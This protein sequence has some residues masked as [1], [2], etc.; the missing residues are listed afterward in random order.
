MPVKLQGPAAA[1]IELVKK[2]GAGCFGE[3]YRGKDLETGH[4]IAVKVE[5]LRSSAPQLAFEYDVAKRLAGGAMQGPFPQGFALPSHF[6][7]NVG[8][9]CALSMPLLGP[10]LEDLIQKCGGRF[11]A[12]TTLMIAEQLLRRLEYL[13]SL[14]IVHRD[15]KPEN[16]MLGRG[17]TEHHVYVIDF[18]LSKAYHDGEKHR[19]IRHKLNLTGT[20]RYASLNAHKGTEQSRRDDLEASSYMLM[21]FLRGAMPWSGLEARTQKEKFQRITEVKEQTPLDELCAGY[22]ESFKTFIILTREIGYDQRPDYDSYHKV[23]KDDFTKLGFVEDYHFDWYKSPPKFEPIG[24]WEPPYQPDDEKLV[25]PA[26]S[27]KSVADAC[28]MANEAL[29]K[30]NEEVTKIKKTFEKWDKNHDGGIDEE[31]FRKVLLSIGISDMDVSTMF[32]RADVNHDG[33]INYEEFMAWIQGDLPKEITEE[34]Y[35]MRGDG[36]VM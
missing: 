11:G 20:A 10:T 35:A 25:R 30:R 1:K 29:M 14:G 34:I 31:E 6:F 7:E 15:I 23:F 27:R 3:V 24:P 8:R 4:E 22:P 36:D 28:E 16:F 18:G 2:I 13:H 26:P 33:T 19:K 32:E 17:S 9:H 21:Y 12:K 5:E